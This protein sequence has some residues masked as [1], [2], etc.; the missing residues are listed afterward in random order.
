MLARTSVQRLRETNELGWQLSDDL[1][2]SKRFDVS[3][4]QLRNCQLS[5]E[6]FVDFPDMSLW[7]ISSAIRHRKIREW[8]W[9]EHIKL[10]TKSTTNYNVDNETRLLTLSLHTWKHFFFVF[11][12]FA[13][14]TR[15]IRFKFSVVF[16]SRA[17]MNTMSLVDPNRFNGSDLLRGEF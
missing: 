16:G 13:Q 6:D 5:R 8:M 12:I 11:S 4:I 14:T 1:S 3:V 2:G 9:T 10:I 15:G 7:T 17:N